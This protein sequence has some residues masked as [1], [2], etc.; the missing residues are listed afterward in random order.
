[1]KKASLVLVGVAVL[2]VHSASA[3]V[4]FT[5]TNDWAQWSSSTGLTATP[6]TNMDSDGSST[7]GLGNTS[8]PGAI[9]TPGA[10][11]VQWSAPAGSFS[12]GPYSP[13]EQGNSS[14]LAALQQSGTILTFDYTT[15]ANNGG[16]YFSLGIL[17]NCSGRFDQLGPSSTVP[18]SNG[19]TRAT[20]DWSAEASALAS[21]QVANGGAFTYFQIAFIWNSNYAPPTPFYVDNIRLFN[22][23]VAAPAN[24]TV[25]VASNLFTVS[26]EAYGMASAVYENIFDN[27]ALPGALIA[28]GVNTLRYP[29]G[30]YADTFHWSVCQPAIGSADGYGMSPAFGVTNYFG[31]M[32]P[33]T[34]FG[35]FVKLLSNS[36]CQAVITINSASALLWNSNHTYMAVPP[37]NGQPREAAAWVA[38]ANG[39]AALYGTTNDITIGLDALSNNWLTVGFWAKLRSSTPAQ[40]QSWA[41]SNGVYNSTYNFL[42]INRPTPVGIKYWEI[43]NE[44]YGT[45]YYG[46]GNGYAENYAVPYPYTT[47]NRADNPLL[48]PI[49]YGQQVNAFSQAM[50]AVDPTLK[51]GAFSSTPLGDYSWDYVVNG[52][53]TNHWTPQV[54]SVCGSN[55]DFLIVHWYPW[56]GDNDDGTETLPVPGAGIPAMINGVSPHTGASSGLRDW[57]NLYCPVPTNVSIFVTEFG[58][59][60]S[61]VTN[62]NG[63]PIIGPVTMLFDVDCYSTWMDFGVSNVDFQELGSPPAF[64]NPST[65]GETYYVLQT[66]HKMA[67][68]G[69]TMVNS[70]SD[71]STL[72]VQ[73]TR[74]QNGYVGLLLLN[75]N[76]SATQTVNVA[77]SNAPL[78]TTGTQYVFGQANFTASQ[79]VPASAPSSNTVSGV[80]NS[81][82]VAIPP[83]T[84]MVYT[85]PATVPVASFTALPPNGVA[86][87]GVTF[88]DTS[89]GGT[90]WFWIFGDGTTTNLATNSVFHTYDTPGAYSVTEIV[91]GLG[92]S[93]TD[94]VANL[95][96]VYDPFTWWQ[97]N[98]F[99]TTNNSGNTAPTADYTGTGMSN[100]NKF[101]AGFSPVDPT[102]YLHIISILKSST[103]VTVIYL[104]ANGDS[105]WSPG[106]ASR[107]NVLEFTV[108]TGSGDYSNNFVSANVTN[109]LSGG[110]GTGVVTNM[111]DSGSAINT[112]SR[113]YRVRVLVP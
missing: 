47:Y 8:G 11:A 10:L 80:G 3:Q 69:D 86:P 78:A 66:L 56:C 48:S 84:M 58:P 37:T 59:S 25:N 50:K 35:S 99:G 97:L 18:L 5:T 40:Y 77:I 55:I 22:P 112:P 103:N 60:G 85:I 106:I 1:M 39:N 14:F 70:T 54:L 16:T 109:I 62:E 76:M 31:Y 102:A 110:T 9:G 71:T 75:E 24:V 113:Y 72:R 57:I 87:L 21:Q 32:G 64:G 15:P 20:I 96:S 91:S 17:I 30:G 89:T 90:N 26:G 51:I 63:R 92:G 4:L 38:Y 83:Y 111:V 28:S 33:S 94:T 101:L 105:T 74:Q 12:Y 49:A 95:I 53:V 82:S 42:A 34:D 23:S 2:L 44:P 104:G 65:P 27:N 61:L 45:G 100:T 93:S 52:G 73:A 68:P 108:G 6:T 79:E 88:T 46:G 36:Q 107:T 67:Q 41:T 81:F 7:N 13:G 29:G 43:G 98:Y 19:W